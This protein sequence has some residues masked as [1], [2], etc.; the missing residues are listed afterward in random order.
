[1]SVVRVPI[2]ALPA[3]LDAGPVVFLS[4]AQ[5]PVCNRH[6]ELAGLQ[7]PCWV[8]QRVVG[9]ALGHS[10]DGVAAA[11]ASL[12]GES[13]VW[14]TELENVHSLWR[15]DEP[16]IV[17][18]GQQYSCS[19]AYY[20]SQKPAPWDRAAWDARKETVMEAAVRAKLAADPSL[21]SLLHATGSRPLLS[22]KRDA[23]WGFDPAK[24][25]GENLLARIWMRL[26]DELPPL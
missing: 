15:Y 19:E 21:A 6:A 24:G 20:H 11:V 10:D 3:T 4:A 16:A 2:P 17:V 5:A 12:G 8:P 14:A 23:V 9:R 25:S 1:M 26:R 22:L 7:L 18:A 13:Y